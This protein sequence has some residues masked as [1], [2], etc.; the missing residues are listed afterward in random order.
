MNREHRDEEHTD[1]KKSK[2]KMC[3][4]FADGGVGKIRHEQS[5]TDGNP[6]AP[7][8]KSTRNKI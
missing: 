4:K 6:T 5:S 1:K 2:K 8:I 7:K 3:Q